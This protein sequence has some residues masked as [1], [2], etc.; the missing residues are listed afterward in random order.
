MVHEASHAKYQGVIID[1]KLR[2]KLQ[3]RT[4]CKK[5]INILVFLKCNT[6][7]DT[8]VRPFAENK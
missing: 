5:G 3:N 4:I 2:W 1:T 8:Y 7:A 6:F